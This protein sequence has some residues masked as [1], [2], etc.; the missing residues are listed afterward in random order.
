MTI[1]W[2]VLFVCLLVFELATWGLYTIWFA[3]G[4]LFATIVSIAGGPMWLQIVL[5]LAVSLL[6]LLF[7][8]PL[9]KKYFN[10]NRVKTNVEMLLDKQVVVTQTIDNSREQGEISYNGMPWSARSADGHIVEA[11]S[12]V[13]IKAIEGVKVIVEEKEKTIQPTE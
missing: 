12:T 7:T 2:F 8:R 1:F 10:K 6:L 11:G 13:R 5:F 3:L 9:A 4:A